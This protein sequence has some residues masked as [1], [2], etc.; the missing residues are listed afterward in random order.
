[1]DDEVGRVAKA[2]DLTDGV[3]ERIGDVGIRRPVESDVTVADLGEPQFRCRLL[4]AA[5]GECG[6][7]L[8]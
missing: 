8:P 3:V 4:N 5:G 2:V 6:G 7:S 1:V